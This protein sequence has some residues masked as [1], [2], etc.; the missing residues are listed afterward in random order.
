MLHHPTQQHSVGMLRERVWTHLARG[1]D[2]SGANV[3]A[4]EV[5]GHRRLHHAELRVCLL[6]DV[7]CLL[8]RVLRRPP[9]LPVHLDLV[10][11]VLDLETHACLERLVAAPL[12]QGA[13]PALQLR[14]DLIG[15]AHLG[16]RDRQCLYRA[17]VDAKQPSALAGCSVQR[18][19]NGRE[20]ATKAA[21]NIP[22]RCTQQGRRQSCPLGRRAS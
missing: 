5:V 9:R 15:L 10:G 8:H 6:A 21:D 13:E 14:R 4:G 3:E 11:E 18:R 12:V 19:H 2:G 17:A 16:T 20:S 7:F 22:G 1:G